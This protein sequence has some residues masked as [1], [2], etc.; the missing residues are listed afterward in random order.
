VAVIYLQFW[1]FSKMTQNR[2]VQTILFSDWFWTQT[3]HILF[4]T[5]Q[6]SAQM[7]MP[8]CI[9][10]GILARMPTTAGLSN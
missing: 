9:C 7:V 10:K 3:V 5:S 1:E 2:E 4:F 6:S 8:L